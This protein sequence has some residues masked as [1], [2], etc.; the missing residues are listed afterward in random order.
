[1]ELHFSETY[2]PS[3]LSALIAHLQSAGFHVCL[4]RDMPTTTATQAR[5]LYAHR[6]T[7]AAAKAA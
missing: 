6:K 3:Q 4:D 7:A 1:M 5:M 2:P